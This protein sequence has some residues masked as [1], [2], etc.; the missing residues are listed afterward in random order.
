[1]KKFLMIFYSIFFLTLFFFNDINAQA[2][3]NAEDTVRPE[4]KDLVF[5]KVETEA[6]FPGGQAAWSKYIA[7]QVGKSKLRKKNYGTCII[8]FMVDK[9]GNISDVEATTMPGSPLAKIAEN[10]IK[11]GPKWIPAQQNGK[12]VNAWRLQ[13]V[14][15]GAALK[16]RYFPTGSESNYVRIRD[17]KENT[18]LREYR[19][20]LVCG[21]GTVAVRMVVDNLYENLAFDFNEKKIESDYRFL[22][23]DKEN[24]IKKL[25]EFKDAENFDAVLIFMQ[26][27]PSHLTET[28]YIE[29]LPMRDMKLYQT[30]SIQLLDLKDKSN[31][32]WEAM[33]TMNMSVLNK[34]VYKDI[35]VQIL[36]NMKA[37]MIYD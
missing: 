3:I 30:I 18:V 36:K 24:I 20:I 17:I 13:P 5:T 1:M 25:E 35:S 23:N 27:D 9:N 14:T 33:I 15:L 31:S 16:K 34:K 22:G 6:S 19:K 11:N 2:N 10:A 12:F 7:N 29:G 4:H 28:Y 26:A 8:K 37:N 32:I 21:A